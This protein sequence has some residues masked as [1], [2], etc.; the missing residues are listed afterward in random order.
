M[1]PRLRMAKTALHTIGTHTIVTPFHDCQGLAASA[2]TTGV[3]KPGP[4]SVVATKPR[5]RPPPRRPSAVALRPSPSYSAP[6]AG[7][8]PRGG[9]IVPSGHVLFRWSPMRT[10]SQPA[11]IVGTLALV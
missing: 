6:A 1:L 8:E 10:S 2:E 11:L 3:L 7:A 4:R 9:R 5:V